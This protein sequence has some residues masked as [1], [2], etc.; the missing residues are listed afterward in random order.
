MDNGN[1]NKFGIKRNASDK[2][3]WKPLKLDILDVP[4]ATQGG[5]PVGR[6]QSPESFNFYRP[7]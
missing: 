2:K 4:S 6:I 1:K 3:L 5:S 7:S